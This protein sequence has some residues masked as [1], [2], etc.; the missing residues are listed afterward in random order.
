MRVLIVEDDEPLRQAVVSAASAWSVQFGEGETVRSVALS[1]I[2]EAAS[3]AEG[4][5]RLKEG[6]DLLIVDVRL[7]DESGLTVVE[8]ANRLDSPP[9]V[10]AVSGSA[11]ANEGFH[12]AALGVRGYLGKPFDMRELRA[13]IQGVFL[14]P[15]PLEHT[16][17][18]QVGHRHIHA[19]QDEVKKAMLRRALQLDGG[20]I[21]RAAKR[22]GVTRAAVQQMLDRY[23]I[24]RNFG[25]SDGQ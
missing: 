16:A 19:V 13:A 8:A 4:L 25:S 22:L 23:G 2:V 10:L 6:C 15:P 14:D 21:T 1:H 18:A 24:P 5:S 20:N 17:M 11:T 7:G 9:V 12:L 3:V